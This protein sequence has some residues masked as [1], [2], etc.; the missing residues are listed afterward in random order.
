MINEILFKKMCNDF[1]PV[2]RK[3]AGTEVCSITL[4]GSHGKG[5]ADENSDFDFEIFYEYPAEH[6]VRRL[7]Y[8]EINQL[9]T[10]WKSKNVL[11]DIW[12]RTYAEADEQLAFWL[13]GQGKPEPYEWTIWGYHILTDIYNMQVLEDSCNKIS[14]WKKQLSVYP[15]ILKTSI[16][17]KHAS[18]LS[19][20]R[21]D[22]HY[23]NKVCRKDIVFLASLTARLIQD[24]L[25]ILYAL[26]GMYYPGD[27]A[28][29]SY[30]EQFSRKPE[31]FEVRI[32]D[33]LHLAK[34]EDAYEAQYR[35]MMHLVD[36]VLALA[37]E[38]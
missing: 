37:K 13:A 36:D 20:W 6:N 12:P 10:K 30:T 11:V 14:E 4:G 27:G 5:T 15:E 2:F 33:I 31:H 8:K 17:K 24:M 34:S 18:S 26:N 28:N 21:A 29:L 22:Y 3:L 19:Y 16:V 9:I 7:A 38:I 1:F 25:Q 32:A 23:Q 35:K